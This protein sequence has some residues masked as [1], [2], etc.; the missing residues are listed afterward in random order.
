MKFKTTYIAALVLL[1]SLLFTSCEK[2]I[3]FEPTT[4]I[5]SDNALTS[6][7]GLQTALIGCYDRMQSGD[8]F[9]GYLYVSGDM[10]GFNVK[11]SGEYA[12]VYE[13][14]QMMNR[15]MSPDNRIVNSMWE[16]AFW[17]INQANTILQAIPEV[18]DA[19]IEA[20]RDRIR[21]ECLFI[22]GLVYFEIMRY[23]G[24][25]NTGE[26]VPLLTEPTGIEGKPSRATIEQVYS[27]VIADLTEAAGLLPENNNRR[28]TSKA[29]K[30]ILA[31]VYFYH[32]DYENAR[33]MA[34]E[35]L[36][37]DPSTTQTDGLQD[38]VTNIYH[39]DPTDETI[40]AIMGNTADRT[41]GTLNGC[42]RKASSAKFSP[43]N[44]LI[45]AF[46]FTTGHPDSVDQRYEKL[47][48]SI[49]GKI[50]TTKFDDLDMS[51]PV[52]RLAELYLIR[53]ESRL[54]EGDVNG[55]R[56]DINV[57]R[58]RAG[59]KPIE[60][61]PT[62]NDFYYERFKELFYEGDYFHN[63]KRLER[64]FVNPDPNVSEEIPWNSRSL[65]FP[66]PQREIDVNP[67]LT[68]N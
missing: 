46:I 57:V 24:N 68:Q 61:T 9:G 2:W 14:I 40:F 54:N 13:E 53:G 28:A 45:K 3:D 36:P 29:A 38:D 6:T 4:S 50:F 66:I 16:Q 48:T 56:E 18:K 26:A 25:P 49:E 1:T 21:G 15:N 12:L 43:E 22:R 59:I 64:T 8:L 67:K 30:A 60:G 52:I 34:S 39:S 10:L 44:T 23:W 31:R 17:T 41:A 33:L 65:L 32:K 5:N 42:F 19:D 11:K 35:I 37:I 7:Q 58:T 63:V 47:F 27:Q 62:Y 51:V 20:N 55:A